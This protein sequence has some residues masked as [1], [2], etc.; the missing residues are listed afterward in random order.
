[1]EHTQL[2]KQWTYTESN[3]THINKGFTVI[4]PSGSYYRVRGYTQL[5]ME[6]KNQ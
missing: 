6:V 2:I 4:V 1:M 3:V 5:K